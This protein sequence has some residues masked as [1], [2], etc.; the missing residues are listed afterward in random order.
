MALI[1]DTKVIYDFLESKELLVFDFDGVLANS[2]EVK[3]NAFAEI[4]K[5][6]G[7]GIVAKVVNHHRMNGGMSR[8][9]K[10]KFYHSTYLNLLLSDYQLLMLSEQFS[11][12]VM[13]AVIAS[14]EV[15]GANNFL[16]NYCLNNKKCIINS[17][18]PQNEIYQIIDKRGMTQYFNDI[19]GSPTSKSNNLM[20]ALRSNELS[21]KDAVFFGDSKSDLQAANELQIDFIGVGKIMHDLLI[22]LDT[23]YYFINDFLNLVDESTNLI[24]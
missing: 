19:Y 10:F 23:H 13:S 24:E 20:L 5:P 12:L 4:Y 7:S 15:L 11:S 9:D 8:F 18:T 16:E 21:C 2:V 6:F 22:G 14:S 3:T 1:E 17:A